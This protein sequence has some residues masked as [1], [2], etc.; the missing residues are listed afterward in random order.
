M[1]RDIIQL[2]RTS[3]EDFLYYETL[4]EKIEENCQKNPDIAIE[5]AK[6]LIEGVSKTILLRLDRSATNEKVNKMDF[7]DLFRNA[8]W[9]IKSHTYFEEDFIY[10]TSSMIQILAEL[11]NQRGDISHGK[12][13]PKVEVSSIASAMMIMHVTDALV[14]YILDSFFKIDLSFKREL[15]YDANPDFNDELD[16]VYPLKTIKYSRALYD[17]D[18]TEYEEQLK[19]YLDRIKSEG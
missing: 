3:H 10:R 15:K 8:C 6:S 4:I 9:R 2:N 18:F 11:R 13:V 16:E 14:N 1:T 7:P 17:Q 19:I 12:A 5:S